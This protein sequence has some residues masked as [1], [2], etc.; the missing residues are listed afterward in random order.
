MGDYSL[1]DA[2]RFFLRHHGNGIQ[3]ISVSDA[4]REFLNGKAAKGLTKVYLDDLRNRLRLFEKGF[5]CD[6]NQIAS[7]DVRI[8]L[9]RLKV[10]ARTHNNFIRTLKTFFRYS[11]SRGWISKELE[12]SLLAARQALT[13]GSA[14]KFAWLI[15][16]SSL[17]S[18][19]VEL[20]CAF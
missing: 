8:F 2:V 19:G 6:L 3:R 14:L 10:A 1:S 13:N 16:G 17:L 12:I 9:S 7:E 11:Q 18:F 4:V 20:D 5:H 15:L